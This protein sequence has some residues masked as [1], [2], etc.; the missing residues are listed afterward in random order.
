MSDDNAS[1]SAQSTNGPSETSGKIAPSRRCAWLPWMAAGGFALLAGFLGQIYFAARSEIVTLREQG[2]L[3][4]IEG[5]SLQQQIEAERILSARRISDLLA[6]LREQ[7]GLAPLKI[8]PLV[9]PP[10]FTPPALA[11]AVWDPHRQEGELAVSKLPPLA[12]DKDYQ[13]WIIDPQYPLPVSA[14]VFTVEPATSDA[15]IRFKPDRPVTTAARFAVSV[16][17]KG[18]VPR[19]EGPI[20]LSSQ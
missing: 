1:T 8:V 13:L 17:R 14:G 11:I 12:P 3:A 19:A 16:E 4:E 10:G 6:D 5:K 18:G 20:V 7:G 2:A 9:F 15:R